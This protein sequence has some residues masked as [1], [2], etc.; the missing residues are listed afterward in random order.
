MA[1]DKLEVPATSVLDMDWCAIRHFSI[2]TVPHR[3]DYRYWQIIQSG[4][5]PLRI[6][7]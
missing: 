4:L 6:S 2:G 3:V 7:N 5:L 1:A